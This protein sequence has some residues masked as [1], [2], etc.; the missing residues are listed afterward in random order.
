MLQRFSPRQAVIEGPHGA[1]EAPEV[2]DLRP[3]QLLKLAQFVRSGLGIATREQLPE[4]FEAHLEA[5]EVL[6][7]AVVEIAGDALPLGL[8]RILRL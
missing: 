4:D 1:G 3:A 5:D 2:R 6:Q 7:G 8:A